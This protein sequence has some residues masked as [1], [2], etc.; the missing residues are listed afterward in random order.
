MLLL[1]LL[2][3]LYFTVDDA[4]DAD[5]G[6]ASP[7]VHALEGPALPPGETVRRQIRGSARPE[8]DLPPRSRC[9]KG[10]NKQRHAQHESQGKSQE[11]ASSPPSPPPV[12]LSKNYPSHPAPRPNRSPV[13]DHWLCWTVGAYSRKGRGRVR[14]QCGMMARHQ[15]VRHAA[16]HF[17]GSRNRK[18][19]PPPK[20][21]SLSLPFMPFGP[22]WPRQKPLGEVSQPGTRPFAGWSA[23]D[24][25]RGQGTRNEG[26]LTVEGRRASAPT[27]MARR[28]ISGLR[29]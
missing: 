16:E 25:A 21:L 24:R 2:L 11:T 12:I 29:E 9:Q 26:P 18:T 4:D 22:R 14:G 19:V 7:P 27:V 23:R 20:P 10:K 3:L 28:G 5:A 15:R 13:V 17:A 8:Q 1:Q 6:A